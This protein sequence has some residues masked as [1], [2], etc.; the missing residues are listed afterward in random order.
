MGIGRCFVHP[1]YRKYQFVECDYIDGKDKPLRK[2]TD[3]LELVEDNRSN[4]RIGYMIRDQEFDIQSYNPIDVH[5]H[6]DEGCYDQAVLFDKTNKNRLVMLGHQNGFA[7]P[8]G[9]PGMIFIHNF[10]PQVDNDNVHDKEY[11]REFI[12]SNLIN[13]EDAK[14]FYIPNNQ[15]M[16]TCKGRIKIAQ[17]VINAMESSSES[18]SCLV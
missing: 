3:K 17:D 1:K 18:I 8:E 9:I 15:N 11:T 13:C 14:E 6:S 10:D 16:F 7:G 4:V 2:S 12:R 5:A